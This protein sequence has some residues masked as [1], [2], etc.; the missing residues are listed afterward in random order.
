MNWL[1]QILA[2][3]NSRLWLTYEWVSFTILLVLFTYVLVFLFGD[4]QKLTWA[5][6][7]LTWS[8]VGIA[9]IDVLKY[10]I[11]EA[12]KD[13]PLRK[14]LS[15]RWAQRYRPEEMLIL[16]NDFRGEVTDL[17]ISRCNR[18][19]A[20]HGFLNERNES[21]RICS[22]RGCNELVSTSDE[23]VLR[24]TQKFRKKEERS[25]IF[26]EVRS[27]PFRFFYRYSWVIT[28]HIFK[29]FSWILL[30]CA[31]LAT[32]RHLKNDIIEYAGIFLG[33]LWII[34]FFIICFK[35]VIFVQ[36]E[37]INWSNK[38]EVKLMG[39]K[40]IIAFIV[41]MV[42]VLFMVQFVIFTLKLISEVYSNINLF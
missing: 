36:D 27:I 23:Y 15:F 42:L 1:F 17:K 11:T 26:A 32:G 12:S 40:G 8:I 7:L 25:V 9:F 31:V 5:I 6:K 19:G 24:T 3:T 29:L 34:N 20:F 10:R 13:K 35:A 37:L 38:D 28:E 39:I 14:W 16:P 41:A 21:E 18:C 30:A 22:F 33:V 4:N 2:D